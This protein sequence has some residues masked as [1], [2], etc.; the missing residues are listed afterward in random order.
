M[1]RDGI[2]YDAFNYSAVKENAIRTRVKQ[3]VWTR[4]YGDKP[5]CYTKPKHDAEL[6]RLLVIKMS[7]LYAP[8][9][10]VCAATCNM[11]QFHVLPTQCVYAFYVDLRTNSD[12][13]PIQH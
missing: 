6:C 8:V 11:Q 9:D 1:R 12:Y 7:A 4:Q 13:F 3:S 2:P 5:R 10:T